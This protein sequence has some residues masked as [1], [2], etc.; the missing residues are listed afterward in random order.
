MADLSLENL[1]SGL[2]AAQQKKS[3]TR[4]SER[5]VVELVAK[6]K[7]LGL[8]GEEL[9][10]TTNGKEY[11]T[12]ER[13]VAEVKAAVRAA[14]GRIPLVDLPS[15][16]GLDLVHCERAADAVVA[17]SGGAI[18]LSQ[19]ELF[20][21]A[22]FDGLA[23]EVDDSLQEAGVVSVGD[24]ARRF[25]LG[26]EMIG[27][28]LS[29]RVASGAVRG[30][31]EAGV[32]YTQA[33]LARIKAQLRGALRGAVSPVPIPALVKELG[34]EGLASL[35]A[36]VPTLIEDLTA[37]GSVAGKLVAGAASWVPASY[38]ASQQDAVKRFFQQNGYIG[39]DT[40][41]Q[42]GIPA[43]KQFLAQHFPDGIALDSAF[44]SPAVV[45][46]VEATVE[47]AMAGGG[48]CDVA[49]HV[50]S[51]LS[52]G[53]T[54]ALLAKCKAVAAASSGGQA[55]VL[56]GTCVVAAAM[57]EGIKQQL[58]E[59]A[60]AAADEAHKAK[61]ARGGG[62]G[63]A[64]AAAAAKAA[65]A[66]EASSKKAAA[67][68]DSGSDDDWDMGGKKGKKGKSGGKKGKGGGGGKAAKGGGGSSGGKAAGIQA[69]AAELGSSSSVLSM[70]SLAQRVIELHPDTE[71][72]GADGDL[73]SAIASELRPPVVAEYERALHAIFTAG[74]EKR[75]RL[76]EAAAA[77]LDAA[78]ERL[79]L[80]A[81]GAELFAS[82]E[83]AS[84]TLQR[85][86]LRGAAAE[87]ADALLRYLAADD[88]EAQGAGG[89]AEGG[90]PL[91]DAAGGA[92][93][94]A[95]R[96][97]VLKHLGPD[98]KGAATSMVDKLNGGSVEAFQAELEAAAEAAGLRLR[99][100][101]KKAERS[102]VFAQRKAWEAAATAAADPSALLALA[103]PLLLARQHGRLV[104]LPGRALG[105]GL[106]ALRSGPG[107]LPEE[108][109]QL[110]S[111][112]HAAVVE[113][114]KL[115]SGGG[116]AEE[117][118]ELARQLEELMPRIRALAVG[119]GEAAGDA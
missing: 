6:L 96:S 93:L 90:A 12:R 113:Q 29:E 37:E 76:R 100:L 114:L 67:A 41:K 118:D 92:L 60:R 38:V 19:G 16:L 17:A 34:I 81:H 13:A 94:P 59:A 77:A 45:D 64:A 18:T 112:F 32:V 73:P 83:A 57:L 80:Y 51:I 1:L 47:E 10:Y 56:S 49:P 46:Q 111:D 35:N 9:L 3:K 62:G 89:G 104:S 99:R 78:Y 52:L 7:A 119:G 106:E 21:T 5:N 74:A 14:G 43:P 108:A 8:L 22:Y 87:C 72:A 98:V 102:L 33:Y 75:R 40:A 55:Q 23:A 69:A 117:A 31:M 27:S 54:A 61:K 66:A 20:S 110:L 39:Y 11:V 36:L 116:G 88:E 68:A 70:D 85:H 91:G 50:P 79:Q 109:C 103:V 25:G 65:A 107:A 105:A 84:A 28:V 95:Q 15:Q 115:Q 82:D 24:L 44:V 4:L 86:L 63:G 26:A 71:G 58:L 97:T 42:Y 2:E 101:D 53:D 48:W 30:R